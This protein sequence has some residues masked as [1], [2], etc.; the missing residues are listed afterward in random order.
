LKRFL[1]AAR[2]HHY[3]VTLVRGKRARVR[4]GILPDFLRCCSAAQRGEYDPTQ[5]CR[6][7][8]KTRAPRLRASVHFF[9]N[10]VRILPT[11]DDLGRL[12]APCYL[13]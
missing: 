3:R 8:Q 5:Y 11:G 2:R 1:A 12:L 7:C 6:A 9:R 4:S 13:Q 10:H